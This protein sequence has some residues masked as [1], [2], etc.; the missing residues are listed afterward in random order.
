MSTSIACGEGQDESEKHGEDAARP[1]CRD[2]ARPLQRVISATPSGSC[3]HVCGT[4]AK[5]T[6]SPRTC[7]DPRAEATAWLC[8]RTGASLAMSAP[9][10]DNVE[11]GR[12]EPPRLMD[13]SRPR[14]QAA[15]RRP[16]LA[17]RGYRRGGSRS[18]S[19]RPQS[20]HGL[21][22]VGG[23][24]SPQTC[25]SAVDPALS[26]IAARV[27][28]ANAFAL[29][30][31]FKRAQARLPTQFRTHA[32]TGRTSAT[33]ASVRAPTRRRRCSRFTRRVV[34]AVTRGPRAP[35]LL[36]HVRT[37]RPLPYIRS[38]RLRTRRRPSAASR[39]PPGEPVR[40][41]STLLARSGRRSNRA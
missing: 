30:A 24:A 21:R 14:V 25:W 9:E 10:A 7:R 2:P 40:S 16:S 18:S 38:T 23:A 13:G 41:W 33:R 35:R 31:A 32:S 19:S 4:C 12:L 20:G 11:G 1:P 28:Y 26:A 5:S 36:S 22:D 15:A 27:G 3:P 17:H 29:S 8:E 39:R 37:G 6:R 34:F